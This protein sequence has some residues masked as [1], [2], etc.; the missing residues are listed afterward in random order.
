MNHILTEMLA[1]YQTESLTDRKNAV[2]EV[3]QEI[4]LCGLSRAGFFQKARAGEVGQYTAKGDW[5]Q[6]QRLKFL[7]ECHIQEH[8]AHS[9]HDGVAHG[10]GREAAPR[11]DGLQG[12]YECIK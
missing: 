2:K 5:S 11:P 8:K 7:D 12:D 10:K 4:V 3:M 1:R 6:K 9:N